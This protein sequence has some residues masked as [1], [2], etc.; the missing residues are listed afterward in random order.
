MHVCVY[1]RGSSGESQRGERSGKNVFAGDRPHSEQ[2]RPPAC[3]QLLLSSISISKWKI[4]QIICNN[5]NVS[6]SAVSALPV[7]VTHDA[8][9]EL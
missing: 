7:S 1:C 6:R 3:R 5:A 9:V 4:R 2:V 8:V